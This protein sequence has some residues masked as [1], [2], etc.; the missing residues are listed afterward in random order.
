M[1]RKYDSY[2]HADELTSKY[3]TGLLSLMESKNATSVQFGMTMEEGAETRRPNVQ[4]NG[5]AYTNGFEASKKADAWEEKNLSR[6]YSILEI[7]RESR[8][9]A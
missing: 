8:K 3:L 6:L 7:P 1:F 4:V 9:G 2:P 5:V